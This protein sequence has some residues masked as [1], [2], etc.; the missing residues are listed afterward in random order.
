MFD[1]LPMTPELQ[2]RF[3]AL[4]VDQ[5]ETLLPMLADLL[6]TV[7]N[8]G[9]AMLLADP[10]ADGRA[11]MLSVGDVHYVQQLLQNGAE[12]YASVFEKQL[13]GVMKQ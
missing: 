2:M 11:A 7:E 8:K 13:N 12:A 6:S 3:D 10:K 9:A 5:Q 1:S 4:E